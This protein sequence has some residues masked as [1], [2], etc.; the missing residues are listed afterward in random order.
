MALGTLHAHVS[1]FQGVRKGTNFCLD[2][3]G[4]RRGGKDDGR[5]S[6][7]TFHAMRTLLHLLTGRER[8]VGQSPGGEDADPAAHHD[9]TVAS[10]G[11]ATRLPVR[12]GPRLR[13]FD[14]MGLE[15]E[16]GAQPCRPG[17]AD[18]IIVSGPRMAAGAQSEPP[19]LPRL[20]SRKHWLPARQFKPQPSRSACGW[21]VTDWT[22][23]LGTGQRFALP[24]VCT[25]THRDYLVYK[26]TAVPCERENWYQRRTRIAYSNPLIDSPHHSF[27]AP[28]RGWLR[29]FSLFLSFPSVA[30]ARPAAHGLL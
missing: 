3:A 7:G 21:Q 22:V 8:D 17:S 6:A 5:A 24:V 29:W 13:R 28:A 27:T 9:E 25:L 26:L 23:R 18:C 12:G 11:R 15:T 20:P 16:S 10:S 19:R 30:R 2:S 14:L 4:G 1:W